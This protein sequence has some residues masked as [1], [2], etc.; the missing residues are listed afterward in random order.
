MR[1][2][3]NRWGAA[4]LTIG[5]ALALAMPWRSSRA[6]GVETIETHASRVAR[7]VLRARAEVERGVRYDPAYRALTFKDGVDTKKSVYPGGDVDP[8]I[9]VCTDLLVRGLRAG[10][11]DLQREV[12]EDAVAHPKAYPSIASGTDFN[13]DHRRVS[14]VLSW[15]QRHAKSLPT[16][17]TGAGDR[18][19]WQAGDVVVWAFNP[20][21]K[22]NPDH[23]GLVSDRARIDGLPKVI[24]NLGPHPT[25][26]DALDDWTI[27][28][29]FRALD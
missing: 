2:S 17:T 25:E 10:G 29:H 27:L 12:H 5:A 9:G 23:V 4:T 19:T 26:D 14:P 1:S 20:C 28:G 3:S 21:P 18:A 6:E 22:C 7:V 8:S 13:I 15:M 24:H 11:L 16:G